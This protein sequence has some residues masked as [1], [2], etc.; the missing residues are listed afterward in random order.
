MPFCVEA[1]LPQQAGVTLAARCARGRR[2]CVAT[3]RE[4]VIDSQFN[5]AG[6]DLRLGESNERRVNLEL[7]AALDTGFGGKVRHLLEGRDEFGT[8]IWI[9]GIVQ[10]VDAKEE[11]HRL[12]SPALQPTPARRKEKNGIARQGTYVR[13]QECRRPCLQGRGPWAR[14]YRQLARIR[15]RHA[16]RLRRCG[17]AQLRWTRRLAWRPRAPMRG[18]GRKRTRARSRARSPAALARWRARWRNRGLR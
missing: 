8:A 14:R 7:L 6:D 11:V 5:S 9:S 4:G 2:V 18:A 13:L 16:D 12:P 17:V 10:R 1:F 3:A 15:R